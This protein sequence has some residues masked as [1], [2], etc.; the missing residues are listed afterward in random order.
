MRNIMNNVFAH[1]LVHAIKGLTCVNANDVSHLLCL[2]TK[3]LPVILKM[4]LR[5]VTFAAQEHFKR[6]IQEN[7]QVWVRIQML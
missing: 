4:V 3:C 7:Y 6:G 2:L 1:L 5:A